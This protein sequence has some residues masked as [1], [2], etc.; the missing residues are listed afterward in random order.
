MSGQRGASR[1]IN[2]LLCCAGRG[3]NAPHSRRRRR[4][5]EANGP[6]STNESIRSLWRQRPLGHCCSL[7]ILVWMPSQQPPK[8]T[9]WPYGL[10]KKHTMIN[11]SRKHG[12]GWSEIRCL[13]YGR[14]SSRI[15]VLHY[16]THRNDAPAWNHNDFYWW[17]WNGSRLWTAYSKS[18][19]WSA[20]RCADQKRA[21]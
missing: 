13:G 10:I 19:G 17:G 12:W 7:H 6:H 21:I 18:S 15:N 9:N 16:W 4:P 2:G 11:M 1:L 8:C 14:L 5:T 3:K 20:A